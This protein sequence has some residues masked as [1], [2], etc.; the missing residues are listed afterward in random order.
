MLKII[1]PD[2]HSHNQTAATSRAPSQ[3]SVQL[4]HFC[5]PDGLSKRPSVTSLFVHSYMLEEESGYEHRL[6][7]S[8]QS[9]YP[10]HTGTINATFS[11]Q[12]HGVSYW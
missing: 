4:Q 1:I 12:C 10:D 6:L 5:Q 7:F 2:L 11:D 3:L 8:D 9:Q